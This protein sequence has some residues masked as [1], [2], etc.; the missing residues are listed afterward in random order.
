MCYVVF[1]IFFIDGDGVDDFVVVE[2][3]LVFVYGVV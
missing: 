3:V 1:K 2:Y